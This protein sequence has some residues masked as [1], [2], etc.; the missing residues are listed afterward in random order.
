M[1]FGNTP[2]YVGDF[3]RLMVCCRKTSDAQICL[4]TDGWIDAILV[5]DYIN[6]K[7]YVVI[8]G[9]RKIYVVQK[10]FYHVVREKRFYHDFYTREKF[11]EWKE[12]ILRNIN[13]LQTVKDIL[14]WVQAKL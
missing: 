8:K 3:R 6:D 9:K 7:E 12:N 4:I 13:I 1:T 11:R 14:T 5:E 10:V 2:G